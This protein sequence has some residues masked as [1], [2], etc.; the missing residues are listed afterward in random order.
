MLHCANPWPKVDDGLSSLTWLQDFSTVSRGPQLGGGLG[1]DPPLSPLAGDMVSMGVLLTPVLPTPAACSQAQ[2]S[3]LGV[4][5]HGPLPDVVFNTTNA[6]QKPPYSCATLIFM[7]IQA[8][9]RRKL[10]LSSL[11][12]WFRENFSYYRSR[13]TNS[14]QDTIRHTLSVNDGFIQVPKEKGES[15]KGCYWAVDP[16]H[17]E[18]LGSGVKQVQIDPSS[19]SQQLPRHLDEAICTEQDQPSQRVGGRKRKLPQASVTSQAKVPRPSSPL[20]LRGDEQK[21]LESVEEDLGRAS[22]REPSPDSGEPLSR[23]SD[24]LPPIQHQLTELCSVASSSVPVPLSPPSCTMD[25]VEALVAN[26]DWDCPFPDSVLS[27]EQSQDS[28]QPLSSTSPEDDLMLGFD[29]K[30]ILDCAFGGELS[31]IS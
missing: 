22:S 1:W 28:G 25:W 4:V 5:T 8:S 6:L 20:L 19:D 17:V 16:Q 24:T 10:R 29:W 31:P 2:Q 21:E 30:S 14:W 26:C 12:E 13:K 27:E 11:Y 15:G 23:P 3:L 18:R 9:E 7:A